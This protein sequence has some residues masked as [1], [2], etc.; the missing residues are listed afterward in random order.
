MRGLFDLTRLAGDDVARMIPTR[1][2]KRMLDLAGG[3][4]GY[5]IAMCRRHA[6]LTVT[7]VELEGAARI[8]REIVR[9]QGM[10]DRIELPGRRHVHRR[11][12]RRATTS[13]PRS[14]SSTTS[15]RT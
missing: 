6:D 9:E 3:H 11:P 15:T 10:A 1:N 2:P 7:I 12:R 14:R 4:G 8:G 5:A 13:R